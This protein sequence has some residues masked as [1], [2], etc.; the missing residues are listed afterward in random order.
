MGHL[1]EGTATLLLTNVLAWYGFQPGH[2][3]SNL[4]KNRR[5]LLSHL[6]VPLFAGAL[7]ALYLVYPSLG[8]P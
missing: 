5:N 3:G 4:G 8:L 6:L 2:R 7:A 1:D